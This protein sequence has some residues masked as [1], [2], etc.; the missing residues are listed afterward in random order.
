[1]GGHPQCMTAWTSWSNYHLP[2]SMHSAPSMQSQ[3]AKG[4][5]CQSRYLNTRSSHFPPNSSISQGYLRGPETS[6][7]DVPFKVLKLS[8][9]LLRARKIEQGFKATFQQARTG[10][11]GGSD[12]KESTYNAGDPSLI[13]GSGRFPGEGNGNSLQ[14]SCLE[15][16]MDRGT[17]WALILTLWGRKESDMTV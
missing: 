16:C 12:S 8:C 7:Q 10:F 4:G 3:A 15:N 1:M 11:P 17:W 14:Y 13:P 2:S 9:V 6:E 5:V